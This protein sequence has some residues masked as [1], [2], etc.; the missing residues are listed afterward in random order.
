MRDVYLML[1][2]DH[3]GPYDGGKRSVVFHEITSGKFP[4]GAI[5]PSA[6]QEVLRIWEEDSFGLWIDVH[7]GFTA[8]KR[9]NMLIAYRAGDDNLISSAR[10]VSDL[11][12]NDI[13]NIP[14]EYRSGIITPSV[15]IDPF[16]LK[17]DLEKKTICFYQA[18][19]RTIGL[20]DDLHDLHA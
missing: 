14:P 5:C 16:F 13:R 10:S 9:G 8:H 4:T 2:Q 3:P 19:G 12:I 1:Y 6:E 15:R 7:C 20:I 11:A 17:Q 18:L